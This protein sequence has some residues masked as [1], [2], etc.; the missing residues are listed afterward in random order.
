MVS[1]SPASNITGE[2]PRKIKNNDSI[3]LINYNINSIIKNIKTL[4]KL[5]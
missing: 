4:Q 5:N 2:Y 1:N 3:A